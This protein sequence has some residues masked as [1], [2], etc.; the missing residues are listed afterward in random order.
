MPFTKFMTIVMLGLSPTLGVAQAG[1]DIT[2]VV[3]TDRSAACEGYVG[4]YHS[5]VTDLGRRVRFDGRMTITAMS[6]VCIL[7]VNQIPNHDFG[8]R[9]VRWPS[10]VAQI[11]DT[12]RIPRTPKRAARPTA[13]GLTPAAILLNGVKWEANPAACFG[14]GREAPGT[15]R[16]GCGPRQVDHPWRYN[17]GSPLNEFRF[18][19]YHAH[20]QG[21][22]MYH[23][24]AA[25]RVLYST[26]AQTF[27]DTD[28][29]AAGPSPVIGFA[30]DGFP[31]FGPCIQDANGTLRAARPSYQLK[32]GERRPVSGY[33]TPYVT[34]VVKTSTYNGQFA[35]D[36]EYVAGTGDLDVC[37]GMTV[38]G[39][40][41]YY[42]T[43]DFP[44]ALRCFT[45]TPILPRR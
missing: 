15:E 14:E 43:Q 28:C 40:Y 38:N 44:Y 34:G 1:D 26:D 12:V 37:N 27:D 19:A 32:Q 45:G 17:L 30:L 31:L 41:G 3:L 6:D 16:I 7:E 25:P 20:V 42:V 23:Y 29:A 24:H 21:R 36:Y 39:Q 11:N 8:S 2:D 35:G 22:G 13:I 33:K 5:S 4:Q 9:D 10:N 18:D